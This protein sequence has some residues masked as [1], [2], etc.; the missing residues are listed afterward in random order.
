MQAKKAADAAGADRFVAFDAIIMHEKWP[1]LPPSLLPN[2][3]MATGHKRRDKNENFTRGELPLAMLRHQVGK[4]Q[5]PA[6]P[7]NRCS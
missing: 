5:T 1:S 2:P 4:D 3:S 6:K 7:S